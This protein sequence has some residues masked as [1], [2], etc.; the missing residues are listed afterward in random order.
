MYSV[1]VIAVFFTI[2]VKIDSS[3]VALEVNVDKFRL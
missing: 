2:F 1:T 3:K